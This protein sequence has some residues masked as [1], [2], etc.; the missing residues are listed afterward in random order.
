MN[1]SGGGMTASVTDFSYTVGDSQASATAAKMPYRGV[2]S[3]TESE[4]LDVAIAA[5]KAR[6]ERFSLRRQR[7]SVP[8]FQ[9]ILAF[10]SAGIPVIVGDLRRDPSYL[11][12]ALES[13]TGE[14]PVYEGIRGDMP[15]MVGAWIQWCQSKLGLVI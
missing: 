8:E 9:A 6:V 12:L 2:L 3:K 11:F 15:A 5:W 13:L 7:K 4:N 10:G 14:D 1:F